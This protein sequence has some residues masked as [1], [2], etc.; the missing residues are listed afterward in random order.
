MQAL[1]NPKWVQM[2]ENGCKPAKMGAKFL[3]IFF[4]K[5]LDN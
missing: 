1:Y 2:Q 3:P 4:E 5:V